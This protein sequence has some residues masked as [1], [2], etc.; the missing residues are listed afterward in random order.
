MIRWL[1]ALASDAHPLRSAV[2]AMSL[3]ALPACDIVSSNASTWV[4]DIGAELAADREWTYRITLH[5][6]GDE[7][8]GYIQFFRI[9]GVCNVRTA[10]FFCSEDC[11]YFG[12]SI[13]RDGEFRIQVTSPDDRALTIQMR[14]D[15][16]RQLT[17]RVIDSEFPDD[18]VEFPMIIDEI[19][20]VDA[21]CPDPTEVV[22]PS[23]DAGFS[24]DR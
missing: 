21:E 17:A 11:A 23:Q 13:E 10:P 12:P 9:D 15:S 2:V 8:G 14:R 18:F 19:S 22:A 16:R 3:I 24:S 20:Q 4:E 7:I 1:A 5:R 6:F